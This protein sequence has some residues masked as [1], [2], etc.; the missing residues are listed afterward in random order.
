MTTDT[1]LRDDGLR[2]AH[3]PQL[4]PTSD[5]WRDTAG[6]TV[7]VPRDAVRWGSI[8]A[9]LITTL[10]TFL[11]LTLLALAVGLTAVDQT[12]SGDQASTFA[13]GGAIVGAIIGLASFFL[14]GFV[15]A[16]T[17]AVIGRPAGALNGF[18]TWALGVVV[19]LMLGALGLSGLLGAA[20]SIIGQVDPSAIQTPNVDPAQ[21]A[22]GIR[23]SALVA[24]VSLAIPAL[25]AALGG[26]LGARDERDQLIEG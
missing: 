2:I 26:A 23:N 5:V 8:A 17:A 4:R 24:F 20:G 3:E 10:T 15:A 18:M 6:A 12:S 9:G 21:A 19:I 7:A 22:D 1:Q 16:R 25:A 13:T 14:G 11:L